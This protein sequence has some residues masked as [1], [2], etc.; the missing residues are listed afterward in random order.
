MSKQDY[1]KVLGVS[2]DASDDEINKAYKKL[3]M[4][5]HPDKNPGDK[6]AEEKF[7]EIEQAHR[8]LTDPKE[9]EKDTYNNMNPQGHSQTFHFSSS[10]GEN[11]F[12][13]THNTGNFRTM[14]D[15]FGQQQF[16]K[17]TIETDLYCSL[18]ELYTGK[19]QMVK[20]K[21]GLQKQITIQPGFK[22]GS[23][24][25]FEDDI[26]YNF[27][28]NI[29]EQKHAIYTREINDL[30]IK[31]ELKLTEA[32]S[33]CKKTIKLLDNTMYECVIPSF[34]KS[35]YILNISNKGMPI[36]KTG[37]FIGYGNLVISFIINLC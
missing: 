5:Y 6:K 20:L 2:R 1:Y 15:I 27:H 35:N 30:H 24:I 4:K 3:A 22:D 23:C 11:F 19:Q 13:N 33:G 10:S 32:L 31:L 25:K 9:K 7:K 14:N 21:N 16:Q 28:I 29:K 8:I 26:N 18:D 12:Q 17:Q 34:T 37:K 36:R